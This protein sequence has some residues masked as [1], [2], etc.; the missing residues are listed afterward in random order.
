MAV[1]KSLGS[2]TLKLVLEVGVDDGGKPV[3]RNKSFDSLKNSTT[4]EDLYEVGQALAGL[5][6]YPL[7]KTL[8]VDQGE[9]VNA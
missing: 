8:R 2:S 1:S 4:D 5:Q 6:K 7:N 3:F 9:L